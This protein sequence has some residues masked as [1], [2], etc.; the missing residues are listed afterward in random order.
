MTKKKKKLFIGEHVL[1]GE[2]NI[3]YL[4]LKVIASAS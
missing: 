1:S 2:V 3:L 4:E